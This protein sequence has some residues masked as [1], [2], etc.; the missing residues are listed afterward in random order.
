MNAMI[1][2][3]KDRGY[4]IGYD[5]GR[6]GDCIGKRFVQSENMDPEC[7]L[8]F[9]E[10]FEHGWTDGRDDS[11]RDAGFNYKV[12]PSDYSFE[13]IYV[14]TDQDIL[15]LYEENPEKMLKILYLA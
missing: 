5:S 7:L 1:E 10:S 12:T 2:A 9:Q 6:I 11:M 13:P 3:A 14:K 4:E 8:A 15:R